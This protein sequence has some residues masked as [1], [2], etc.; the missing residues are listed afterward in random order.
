MDA[1]R[2]AWSV[3]GFFVHDDRPKMRQRC[4]CGQERSVPA[5]DR[6]WTPPEP[7]RD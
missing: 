5:W 7:P 6:S 2:H 3:V 4:A 1:H